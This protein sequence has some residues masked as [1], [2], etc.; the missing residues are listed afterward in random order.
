MRG[1]ITLGRGSGL[2]L[3]LV[4]GYG[5][6][7]G[8][9][10]TNA[11]TGRPIFHDQIA[12]H[13]AGLA[14]RSGHCDEL[15]DEETQR[16]FQTA[17]LGP[18]HAADS[19]AYRPFLSPPHTALFYIPASY[20]PFAAFAL[21]AAA[22]NLAL[23][24]AALRLLGAGPGA[25]LAAFG[26]YPVFDGFGVGQNVFVTLFLFAAAVRL[27]RAG[28]GFRAGL[29]AGLV[30]AYKP[31]LLCGV[32]LLWLLEARRD[33]RALLGLVCTVGALAAIDVCFLWQPSVVYAG[34]MIGVLIG[35]QPL[36]PGIT[37]GGEF[38]VGQLFDLLFPHS[39]GLAGALTAVTLVAGA[40]VFARFWSRHRADRSLTCAGAMVLTLWIIPHAHRYEWT[41][42]VLPG[43]LFWY[44]LPAARPRLLALY[45]GFYLVAALAIRLTRLQLE[46]FGVA[47][48]PAA[49]MLALGAA[50]ILAASAA[51]LHR[52]D[53][54][55]DPDV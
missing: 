20:L 18:E 27:W 22:L 19:A 2:V 13:A 15:Y 38:T 30:A 41:L 34:R 43:L 37:A 5:L 12:F 46:A 48:H 25:P 8:G 49:P 35:Q 42:L 53:R 26:F 45:A 31:H 21:L 7:A 24:V 4:L 47:L 50:V 36:W 28:H 17:S 51:R 23:L 3:A 44:E 11:M 10:R 1:A 40:L 39:A 9:G 55:R 6:W 14:C 16:A 52:L 33:G 29:V 54:L 32:S